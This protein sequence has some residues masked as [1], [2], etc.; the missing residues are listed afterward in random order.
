MD[1]KT[2]EMMVNRCQPTARTITNLPLNAPTDYTPYGELEFDLAVQD[3]CRNKSNHIQQKQEQ[4]AKS[5]ISTNKFKHT[6]NT[7]NAPFNKIIRSCK[8]VVSGDVAVGKTSLINRFGNGV[9]SSTHRSTIGVDFDL[10][11]FNVLG[12]PYMLQVSR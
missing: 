1:D 7:V 4:Q 5:L 3:Y 12:Q 10:Q 11:R 9:Y 2:D 8:V 6:Y